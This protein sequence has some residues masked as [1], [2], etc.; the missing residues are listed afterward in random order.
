[1]GAE[2]AG[3]NLAKDISKSLATEII[4][5]LAEY[6]VLLFRDQDLDVE[7]HKKIA[8]HFGDIFIHPNFNTGDHDPEVVNI[9]RQPGDSRIVGED[10]HADTTMMAEPPMG[11]LLYAL[12]TPPYGGDTFSRRSGWLMK[13]FLTI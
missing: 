10:W 8:R 13:L 9:V 3:F 4:D 7:A 1:M 11:A 2:I 6:G 5:A 12:E